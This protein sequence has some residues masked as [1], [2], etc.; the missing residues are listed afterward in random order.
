[1]KHT[2]PLIILTIVLAILLHSLYI[3]H[4]ESV[5]Y[6]KKIQKI[7]SIKTSLERILLLSEQKRDSLNER[8]DSIAKT[9]R[10]IIEKIKP[11]IVPVKYDGLSNKQL[12][13]EMIKAYHERKK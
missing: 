1:M 5:E 4:V 12:E 9:K 7:D 10:I 2:I 6:D 8:I 11:V 13:R 3:S